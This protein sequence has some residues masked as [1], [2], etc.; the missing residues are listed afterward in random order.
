MI[1]RPP[2]STQGVSSAAS[3]VY[4]RQVKAKIEFSPS[5][6]LAGDEVTITGYGFSAEKVTAMRSQAATFLPAVEAL[7]EERIASVKSDITALKSDV[8]AA[9]P[10]AQEARTAAEEAKTAASGLTPLI[11]GAI[12]SLIQISRRIAG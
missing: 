7:L 2:R 8:A 4:K 12:V 5:S 1:R 11:Y 10:A 9:A 6:G 3:D